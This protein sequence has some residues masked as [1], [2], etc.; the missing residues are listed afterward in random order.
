MSSLSNFVSFNNQQDILPPPL[1][2]SA[3][4]LIKGLEAKIASLGLTELLASFTAHTVDYNNPHQL[5]FSDF[6]DAVITGLYP[7]YAKITDSP[8]SL[9]DYTALMQNPLCVLELIRRLI[10]NGYLYQ[11]GVGPVTS[12]IYTA[13]DI[14]AAVPSFYPMYFASFAMGDRFLTIQSVVDEI[15]QYSRLLSNEG[16]SLT[17]L[18]SVNLSDTVATPT[19]VLANQNGYKVCLVHNPDASVQLSITNVAGNTEIDSILIDNTVDADSLIEIT[20]SMI[21]VKTTAP[22]THALTLS[23]TTA[24]YTYSY[25][26]SLCTIQI[27]LLGTLL[28][29]AIDRMIVNAGF[30]PS[31]S[32]G[33]SFRSLMIYPDV[34]SSADIEALLPSL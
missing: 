26:G 17:T 13:D 34:L 10:L 7:Y 8:L 21:A 28:D 11:D 2:R 31:T 20:P 24:T 1:A 4:A 15:S 14:S 18:V 12:P 19:L 5:T 32:Q 23:P 9:S 22:Y 6:P 30:A 29:N 16:F 33:N 3:L 27:G 25:K